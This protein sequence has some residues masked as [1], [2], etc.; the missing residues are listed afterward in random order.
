M[1]SDTLEDMIFNGHL[2]QHSDVQ[3][4]FNQFYVISIWVVS[5]FFAKFYYAATSPLF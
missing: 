4:L 2:I 3:N 5:N 1:S